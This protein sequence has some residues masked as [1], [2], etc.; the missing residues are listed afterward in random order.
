MVSA[1]FALNATLFLPAQSLLQPMHEGMTGMTLPGVQRK[2]RA[3]GSS[4]SHLVACRK[5]C[6]DFLASASDNT[7]TCNCP[8]R[9]NTIVMKLPYTCQPV[10]NCPRPV[11]TEYTIQG[12]IQATNDDI[13]LKSVEMWATYRHAAYEG[14]GTFGNGD[15]CRQWFVLNGLVYECR[16]CRPCPQGGGIQLDCSNIQPQAVLNQ[17]DNGSNNEATADVVDLYSFFDYCPEGGAPEPSSPG[18]ASAT[19]MEKTSG[20][21][22]SEWWRVT[23]KIRKRLTLWTSLI[24]A[25]LS[26]V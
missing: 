26:W 19:G 18:T 12:V 7:A 8:S 15:I 4:S 25:Y 20:A 10:Q 22:S 9:S 11:C 13:E 24:M 3:G 17:C 23:R 14:E 5:V 16:S 2:G 21:S 1:N 6:D